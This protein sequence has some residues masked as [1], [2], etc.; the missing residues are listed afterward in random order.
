VKKRRKKAGGGK[1][2]EQDFPTALGNP[3]KAAGFPL[4]PPHGGD[5]SILN[6]YRRTDNQSL[7]QKKCNS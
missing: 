1:V 3:A 5:G 2:Q 4:F 7:A 6:T